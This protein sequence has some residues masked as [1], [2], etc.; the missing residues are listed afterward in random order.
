MTETGDKRGDPWRG[1]DGVF[2][3]NGKSFDMVHK[4]KSIPRGANSAEQAAEVLDRFT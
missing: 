4:A 3:F 2:K 1:G